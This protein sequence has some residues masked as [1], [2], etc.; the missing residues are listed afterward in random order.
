MLARLS[1]QDTKPQLLLYGVPV[2]QVL[3]ESNF[4]IKVVLNKY[5]E[6]KIKHLQDNSLFFKI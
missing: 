6:L 4:E 5:K 1:P 3:F 2:A